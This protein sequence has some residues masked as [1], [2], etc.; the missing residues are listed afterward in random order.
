M[1]APA[2]NLRLCGPLEES[3]ALSYCP[4]A[5]NLSPPSDSSLIDIEVATI[6]PLLY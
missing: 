3:Y 6:V 5:A 4:P 1:A 2:K